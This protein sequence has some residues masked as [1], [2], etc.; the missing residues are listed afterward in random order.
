[1]SK[2]PKKHNLTNRNGVWYYRHRVPK[3]LQKAFGKLVIQLSLKTKDLNEAVKL[4]N[5]QDVEWD[6]HFEQAKKYPD[7]ELHAVSSLRHQTHS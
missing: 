2:V 7:A 5:I 3:S 6:A 4:R 1:M